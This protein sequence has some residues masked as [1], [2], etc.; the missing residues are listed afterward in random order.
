V[1]NESKI[2][3]IE[4]RIRRTM[5]ETFDGSTGRIT[6]EGRISKTDFDYVFDVIMLSKMSSEVPHD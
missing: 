4:M 2:K 6:I 1:R 3:E 5:C